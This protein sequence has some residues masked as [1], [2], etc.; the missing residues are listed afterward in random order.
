MRIRTIKTPNTVQYAIIQD[1]TRDGKRTTK[2]YENI[3]NL[4]KLKQRAGNEEPLVWL[5]NYV[6]DLNIKEK[7]KYTD[8]K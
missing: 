1:I 6:R 7:T 2:V 4:E 8:F 3:G 5:E